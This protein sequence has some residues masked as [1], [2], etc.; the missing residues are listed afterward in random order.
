LSSKAHTWLLLAFSTGQTGSTVYA[1]RDLLFPDMSSIVYGYLKLYVTKERMPLQGIR[2]P[3]Y[4]R[5]TEYSYREVM[6]ELE[7]RMEGEGSAE[8]DSLVEVL[9]RDTY[10]FGKLDRRPCYTVL[11]QALQAADSGRCWVFNLHAVEGDDFNGSLLKCLL[12]GMSGALENLHPQK[13]KEMCEND[14]VFL[15]T[16]AAREWV[17]DVEA[18]R[19]IKQKELAKLTE[20]F[21]RLK[22]HHAKLSMENSWRRIKY[23]MLWNR[24]D[25]LSEELELVTREFHP[26]SRNELLH[27]ALVYAMQRKK[28]EALSI[29]MEY[30]AQ[31]DRLNVGKSYC[32]VMF[33][34]S[35]CRADVKAYTE[36]ATKVSS[37]S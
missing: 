22:E 19:R 31:V 1:Q 15:Q 9:I 11:L 18:E 12:H 34:Y 7:K 16:E 32:Y 27:K 4:S 25:L 29:L 30:G 2:R 13:K 8:Q 5:D 37:S 33:H 17:R 20:D 36:A 23:I 6:E 26:Q 35:E 10:A 28:P 14:L 3:G 21:D 24:D